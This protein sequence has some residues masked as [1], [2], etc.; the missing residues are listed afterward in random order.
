VT[1]TT[2]GDINA[3]IVAAVNARIEAA[4]AGA[5]AGDE[6]IRPLVTAA[7]MQEIEVKDG[8]SYRSKRVPFLSE[9]LRKTIQE[10]TRA[11]VKRIVEE[12]AQDIEDRVR[13]CMAG[14]VDE[15]AKGITESFVKQSTQGYGVSVNIRYPGMDSEF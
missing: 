2:E 5:L 10:A 6:G 13:E 9:V 11:A 3:V 14:A 8:H 7:L 15:F 4:V 12:H 1:S